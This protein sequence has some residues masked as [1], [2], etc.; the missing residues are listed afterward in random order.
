M[1]YPRDVESNPEAAISHTLRTS[2][3]KVCPR[4]TAGQIEHGR[5]PW[6]RD[7]PRGD[8]SFADRHHGQGRGHID[9]DDKG[10]GHGL[11]RGDQVPDRSLPKPEQ[12]RFDV[13]FLGPSDRKQLV[14]FPGGGSVSVRARGCLADAYRQLVATLPNTDRRALID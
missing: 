4:F 7:R 10:H 11:S 13:T 8:H 9:A 14:P 6:D 3:Y 2:G 12:R 5:E 1:E